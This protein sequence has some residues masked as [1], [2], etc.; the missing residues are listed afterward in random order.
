MPAPIRNAALRRTALGL[1][2]AI[3]LGVAGLATA[4]SNAAGAI[5]GHAAQ[6]DVVVIEN[7]ATGYRRE[8]TVGADGGF[9]AP[10][11]PSGSYRVTLRRAD[12]STRVRERVAVSV[13]T[14]TQVD[15]TQDE[16]TTLDAVTVRAGTI[17]PVDVSSVESATVLSAQQIASIPVARDATSVALL[18]PGT[19]RGDA[20]FGNLASF[21][22]SSVAENAYYVNGFNIT[23]SFNNLAF[24]QIP[25]EAIAEQQVKTGG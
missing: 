14:G 1:S 20:A 13:G 24:A 3:S 10:Q 21:G 19:V 11:T 2:L 18:A 12:G 23:N 7:A 15:F 4:Q 9:R 22:G 17:N 16:T 25:F 5:H 6:G 8:I